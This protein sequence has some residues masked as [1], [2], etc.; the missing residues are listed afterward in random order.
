MPKRNWEAAGA[1]R[2]YVDAMQNEVARRF[3]INGTETHLG[4]VRSASKPKGTTMNA[5]LDPAVE[6]NTG[7]DASIR[8]ILL[9]DDE[10]DLWWDRDLAALAAAGYD[11]DT[12]EDG[13]AGW[14]ALQT[15]DYDLLITDNK[16]PMLWGWELIKRLHDHG[17]TLPIIFASSSLPVIDPEH[18]L[19]F[20][21]VHLL[22][23]PVSASQLLAIVEKSQPVQKNWS[24][25]WSERGGV[26]MPS[27]F[28][29][30]ARAPQPDPHGGINE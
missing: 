17:M 27:L 24:T 8:S 11:V 18:E 28:A 19:C 30:N 29:H 15:N 5:L 14:K 3:E 1:L 2:L 6:R 25:N 4:T 13:E 16:M 23:K 22:E 9:V 21:D 20:H 10:I 7:R 26:Q 12:A